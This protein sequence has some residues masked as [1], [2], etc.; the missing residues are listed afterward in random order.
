MSSSETPLPPR[1]TVQIEGWTV[2]EY[3]VLPST[4]PVAGR[5]PAWHAV[6]ADTQTGGRGRTGRVWVSDVGGLWISAV[7]P[8]AGPR[9]KWAILPL[10]VGWA[11][12]EA[13]TAQGAA[14]LRLRWPNDV[15]VGRRKL[16]G[17][18]VEQFRP[19]TAVV[20]IGL[21]VFNQPRSVDPS[22][23][24]HTLTLSELVAGPYDLPDIAA[25]V[26]RC[27]RAAHAT[28]ER[29]QF[30]GMAEQIN[31]RWDGR[32]RVELTLNAADA[33]LQGFFRGV[34][35]QG[36]LEVETDRGRLILD[37]SQV[38]LLRELE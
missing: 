25:V 1:G 20:G 4:N 32:R 21:N 13:L 28:I 33:A 7:V 26:L 9:S 12:V 29:D 19:D 16:A 34:D 27:L 5:L 14:G 11:L 3:D 15:L 36:R 6:R 18:L 22:L 17:L 30:A 31:Q 38:A 24:G 23:S 37:A 8:V 10:A 35:A 2:H